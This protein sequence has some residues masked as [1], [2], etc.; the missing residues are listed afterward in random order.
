M[1]SQNHSWCLLLLMYLVGAVNVAEPL[2]ASQAE[3]ASFPGSGLKQHPFLYV[4]E[5]DSRNSKAQSIFLVREGK[6]AWQYSIP[7]HLCPSAIQEFDDVTMLSNGNIVFACMSGAGIITPEKNLIW[8]FRCPDGT[9][10]HSCQPIGKDTVLLALNGKVGKVLV[11]NTATNTIL[12]EIIVPTGSTFAH[13]QFRHVTITPEKKTFMVGLL[14]E[15]KVVEMDFDG[16]VVWSC[17][18]SSAWSAIRLKN[19]NTLI[20]CDGEGYTRE[21]NQK[22]EIVWEFTQKDA[23]FKLYNNQTANRLANGNTVICNWVAGNKN[24][25]EWKTSVQAFEVTPAKDVVW[26]LSSWDKPDLGPC[27]CIQLLD[28]PGNADEGDLQR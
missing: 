20:S 3:S 18:A 14:A 26:A 21:V 10:T 5:W 27:T 1:P 2:S 17:N 19:G 25:D 6:V 23:P 9:E 22:G 11:I 13:Y 28:E 4:G 16:K 7:L 15:K 8:Q 24:T 12:K